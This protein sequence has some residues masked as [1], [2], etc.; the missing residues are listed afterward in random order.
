MKTKSS[1]TLL[2]IGMG[3]WNIGGMFT[4]SPGVKYKGAEPS[5]RNGVIK[6]SVRIAVAIVVGVFVAGASTKIVYTC[7][8][9]DGAAGC[10]SFDKAI[11]HPGD[12]LNNKQESLVRFSTVFATTS[13]LGFTVMGIVEAA[14]KKQKPAGR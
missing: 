4:A 5:Y 6:F 8:P 7:V 10:M 14:L 11:M 3:T 1:K 2:P 9:I 13:L 12:L